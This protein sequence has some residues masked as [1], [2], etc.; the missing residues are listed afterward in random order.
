MAALNEQQE[1]LLGRIPNQYAFKDPD[2][3]EPTEV[4]K[5]RKVI[6]AFDD[7]TSKF[8]SERKKK[9]AKARKAAIETVYFKQPE[10]ALEII[11]ALEA[12]FPCKD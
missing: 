2:V 5:A 8:F 4:K 9:F 6:A 10:R 11:K 1:Y 7:K 12:E 3:V